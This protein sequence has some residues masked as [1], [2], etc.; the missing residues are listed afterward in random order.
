MELAIQYNGRYGLNQTLAALHISK[1]TWHYRRYVR[2]SLTEK[3]AGLRQ[4]L[5]E[6]AKEHPQYGYRK[7]T[8]ELRE[9]G[10]PV[11]KKVVQNLQKAWDLP[12]LRSIRRP[13]ASRIRKALT[14]LG[15]RINLVPTL[16]KISPL[17]LLYTDITELPFDRGDQKAYLMAI[18]DHVSKYALGWAFGRAKDTALATAAWERAY[19]NLRRFRVVPQKV[20]IHHDQDAIYTS[21]EWLRKV[22][23][24]SGARVSYSLNGARGNTAMESFNG[25]FKGE[26]ES[27]FWEQK[28]I[29][30]VIRVVETRMRYYNAPRRHESLG[31]ISP[32]NF[33]IKHGIKAQ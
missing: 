14:A 7:V 32:E 33:L 5:L 18:I 28:D 3:Y 20:V 11:N 9:R 27:I 1:G 30:G 25:H 19:R 21:H 2:R 15:G 16:K 4:P 24:Q 23:V 22:C 26:N 13:A 12:L 8:Q 29:K 17:Y 6:I 31:Q 10:W